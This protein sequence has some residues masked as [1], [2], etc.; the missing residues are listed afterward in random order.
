M[1]RPKSPKA[2]T[3]NQIVAANLARARKERGWTQDQAAEF[4]APLLGFRWSKATFSVAERSVDGDRIRDFSADELVAFS[5]A[6]GLPITWFLI[7]PEPE[8]GSDEVPRV[9]M[10][11]GG[12]RGHKP[13]MLVDRL[14]GDELERRLLAE[15]LQR[16][17]GLTK[18]GSK[19]L[20]ATL[21]AGL[22]RMNTFE[23]LYVEELRDWR[24][25][26]EHVTARVE[27]MEQLAEDAIERLGKEEV[28]DE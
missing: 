26:L 14:F 5:I 2:L 4:L 10:P 11:D 25:T 19:E 21:R 23:Q 15:R 8:D 18:V 17:Y 20:P 3:P 12:P 9:A 22:N 28:D 24:E 7:P 16:L 27:A 13:S 1:A 6:F